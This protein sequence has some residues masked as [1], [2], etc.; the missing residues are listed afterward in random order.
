[1]SDPASLATL[2][3]LTKI[4]PPAFYTDANLL[5]LVVSTLR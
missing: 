3:F 1:M 5:A 4:A 2:E